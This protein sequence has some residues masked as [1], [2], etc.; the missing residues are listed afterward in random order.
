MRPL[1]HLLGVAAVSVALMSMSGCGCE[2]WVGWGEPR[3]LELNVTAEL[4]AVAPLDDDEGM[5]V[6][7]TGL[8]VG[9]EG[10]IVIWGF[11]FAVDLVG[12]EPFVQVSSFGTA[13]LRSILAEPGSWWIVGDAGTAAVSDD[14][15]QTWNAVDL[16]TTADL[17][18]IAR[19]ESQLVVAGD[20]LVLVQNTDETWTEVAPS[21]G[22]WGQLRALYNHGG[23]LYAVGLD[24]VIWS[25]IDPRDEW[26]AESSG[27]QA[28]L[29]AIGHLDHRREGETVVAV[30]AGGTLLLRRSNGWDQIRN[31]ENVDLIDYDEGHALGANGDLFDVDSRAKPSYIDT[32][33]GAGAI[34]ESAGYWSSDLAVVGNDGAAA[35]MQYY[36]CPGL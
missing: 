8:A 3:P 19:V 17:R 11:D 33:P 13:D 30:G 20:E 25:T 24:G 31:G 28:D 34:A 9:A 22:D 21:D 4:H 10:T 2:G 35:L 6:T 16:S 26:V 32:I 27:T 7:Y 14:R 5:P 15:G 23:R 29:F 12:S 18:A 1:L 36:H